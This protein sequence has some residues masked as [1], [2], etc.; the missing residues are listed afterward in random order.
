MIGKTTHVYLGLEY[1]CNSWNL[2][3]RALFICSF[4]DIY[5]VF[6]YRQIIR[7]CFILETNSIIFFCLCGS[8]IGIWINKLLVIT[9]Y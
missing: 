2:V 4:W 8:G 1:D 3:A 9:D 6:F 7:Y 5:D